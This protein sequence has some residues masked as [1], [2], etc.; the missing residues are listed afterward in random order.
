MQTVSMLVLIALTL[1]ATVYVHW[2]LPYHTPNLGQL[3]TT[4][5][6]LLGS[7]IGFGWIM[8]RIYSM[9][10]E[11]NPILVFIAA[12]CLVHVPAAAILFIK[13]RRPGE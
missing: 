4:R 2:R 13:A 6:I 1:I 9:T 12:V 5:L 8:A 7:G 3:R 11:L 10:T